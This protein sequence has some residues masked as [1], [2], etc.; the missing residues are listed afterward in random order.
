LLTIIRLFKDIKPMQFYTM[1]GAISGALSLVF[2]IPV[3][4]EYFETGLVPRFPTAILAAS[5]ATIAFIS[6]WTGVIV[7]AI[8]KTRLDIKRLAYLS[9]MPPGQNR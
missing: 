4:I 9:Y 8:K 5:L 3:V 7:G 1:L 2:G 6:L